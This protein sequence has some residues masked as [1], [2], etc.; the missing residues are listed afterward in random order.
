MKIRRLFTISAAVLT[1]ISLCACGSPAGTFSALSQEDTQSPEDPDRTIHFWCIATEDPD[2]GIMMDDINQLMIK[3]REEQHQL[4]QI[5]FNSL[6]SQIQPHFLYNTLDCIHW[7]ASADGNKEVS[8]L[9]VALAA[10]YRICLSNGKDIIPL[11]V[12]LE[13]I[14]YYLIIQNKRY[15]DI[16][17]YENKVDEKY[18]GVLLPKLTL[19]PLVENSIYHGPSEK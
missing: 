5:R 2:A 17:H 19:Q 11:S 9:I 13:Q 12:E 3:N 7:Q 16:I 10:Y 18:L 14:R 1:V 15:G 8:D 6:Q 4:D